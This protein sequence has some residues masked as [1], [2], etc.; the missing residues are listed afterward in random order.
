MMLTHVARA[1]IEV[2]A[3]WSVDSPEA[4]AAALD[5]QAFQAALRRD[6]GQVYEAAG[7]SDAGVSAAIQGEIVGGATGTP[8]VTT[9]APTPTPT[10]P[11]PTPPPPEPATT[12]SSGPGVIVGVAAVGVVG[13]LALGAFSVNR[14]VVRS[15][16]QTEPECRRAE[17]PYKI[18][19]PS[20]QPTAPEPPPPPPTQPPRRGYAKILVYTR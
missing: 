2:N 11:E 4:L 1:A 10:P 15:P 7:L 17:I 6:I 12:D 8:L 5:A 19:R 13:V 9:R 16:P 14:G 18:E 20:P 3:Q